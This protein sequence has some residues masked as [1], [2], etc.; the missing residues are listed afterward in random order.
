MTDHAKVERWP[1]FSF[2]TKMPHEKGVGTCAICGMPMIRGRSA[3]G[4]G[5]Q[6]EF[7]RGYIE[8]LRTEIQAAEERIG[9]IEGA[10]RPPEQPFGAPEEKPLEERPIEKPAEEAPVEE[11]AEVGEEEEVP[12]Y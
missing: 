9:E 2:T 3:S 4:V 6:R 11:G 8:D 10:E 5:E 1:W 12:P 7:L